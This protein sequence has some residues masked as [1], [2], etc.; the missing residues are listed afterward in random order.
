M[1]TFIPPEGLE[2]QS[3]YAL[4]LYSEF[5]ASLRGM[6]EEPG[7]RGAWWLMMTAVLTVA[8]VVVVAISSLGKHF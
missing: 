1:S 3:P 8:G 4:K 6:A 2:A 7:V 5:E